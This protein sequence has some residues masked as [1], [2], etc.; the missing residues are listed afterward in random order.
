MDDSHVSGC[1]VEHEGVLVI[2][3]HGDELGALCDVDNANH[4]TAI[5][6]QDADIRPAGTSNKKV[7][8]VAGYG[9][10]SRITTGEHRLFNLQ[11]AIREN[12]G[13]SVHALSRY[14]ELPGVCIKAEVLRLHRQRQVSD[15][16]QIRNG[17]SRQ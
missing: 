12:N 10:N 7:S 3:S 8:R 9:H 5:D 1:S 2:G 17:E 13:D 6:I 11:N 16:L 14:K 15:Y 4:F